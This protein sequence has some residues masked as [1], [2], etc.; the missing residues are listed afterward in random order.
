MKGAAKCSSDSSRRCLF[1]VWLTYKSLTYLRN[2]KNVLHTPPHPGFIP[3]ADFGFAASAMVSSD[4]LLFLFSVCDFLNL[5]GIVTSDI[6]LY[7]SS[8]SS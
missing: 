3:V 7:Y 1:S 4:M 8:V 6:D 2:L 5:T